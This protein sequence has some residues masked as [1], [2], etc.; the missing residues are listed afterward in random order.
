MRLILYQDGSCTGHFNN[1]IVHLS[2]SAAV[3]KFHLK[4][5]LNLKSARNN[6]LNSNSNGND[7][8]FNSN[9][10]DLNQNNDFDSRNDSLNQFN[11]SKDNNIQHINHDN[12][13]QIILNKKNHINK[14]DDVSQIRITATLSPNSDFIQELL[15]LLNFRNAS[16]STPYLPRDLLNDVQLSQLMKV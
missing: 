6:D 13:N 4:D 3:C 1:V 2:P 5:H 7:L 12:I 11:I 8:I 14:K 16:S 9:R 10:K 15:H